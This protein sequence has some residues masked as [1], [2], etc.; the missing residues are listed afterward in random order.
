MSPH[1]RPRKSCA[2]TPREKA[3]LVNGEIALEERRPAN[4]NP[5]RSVHAVLN[6]LRKAE[7]VKI[8]RAR[9]R[10]EPLWRFDKAGAIEADYDM[11]GREDAH[12]TALRVLR[13]RKTWTAR[14]LGSR[15]TTSALPMHD[16][17]YRR[18]SA[19]PRTRCDG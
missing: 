19:W 2:S 8:L 18:S 5:Q 15:P 9:G 10:D 14:Q 1:P 11:L 13:Y 4:D 17:R 12:A 3:T 16:V 6:L 7:L